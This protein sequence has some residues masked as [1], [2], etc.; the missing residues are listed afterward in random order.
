[1][2]QFITDRILY[3]HC[4]LIL[5]D[6]NN[7]ETRLMQLIVHTGK[8]FWKRKTSFC[9]YDTDVKLMATKIAAANI[10]AHLGTSPKLFWVFGFLVGMNSVV[11][12]K[13]QTSAFFFENIT[14]TWDT[15]TDIHTSLH[16]SVKFSMHSTIRMFKP[17]RPY[18]FIK[19]FLQVEKSINF[20]YVME[21]SYIFMA[22]P[23]FK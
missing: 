21:I 11:F 2:S 18:H 19:Y 12:N 4:Y 7:L 5:R 15:M 20:C 13:R 3:I 14:D 1:M 17:Y 8:L 9:R 23:T 16:N 6:V 22:S 10:C